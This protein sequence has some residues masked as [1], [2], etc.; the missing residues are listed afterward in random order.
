MTP[1]DIQCVFADA[2]WA[3]QK[4]GISWQQLD[5]WLDQA[6]KQG[7]LKKGRTLRAVPEEDM[8]EFDRFWAVYPPNRRTDKSRCQKLWWTRKL[9]GQIKEIL[10]GIATIRERDEW[11]RENGKFVPSSATFLQQERWH[12]VD[13]GDA[14][15][16]GVR[17]AL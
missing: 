7:G 12:A 3:A 11:Y 10:A 14:D 5:L 16:F 17:A 9:D 15:P 8:K 2:V 1:E 4:A 13:K 6:M